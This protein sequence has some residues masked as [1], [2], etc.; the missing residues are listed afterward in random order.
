MM[1]AGGVQGDASPPAARVS[2]T[3]RTLEQADFLRL[4]T[5]QL[6]HQDPTAPVDNKDMLGQLAQFSAVAGTARTNATLDQIA[7]RL[8]AL[9]ARLPASSSQTET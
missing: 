1:R 4:L 6:R 3:S 5:A 7:A 8:D 9:L 2:A